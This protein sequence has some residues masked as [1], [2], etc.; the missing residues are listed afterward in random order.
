MSTAK[1]LSKTRNSVLHGY[2]ADYDPATHALTFLS[3]VPDRPDNTMHRETRFVIQTE[4]LL[5][6]GLRAERLATRM[7]NLAHRIMD[8]LVL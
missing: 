4:D 2:P 8:E 1:I 6:H 5:D 3:A 7:G